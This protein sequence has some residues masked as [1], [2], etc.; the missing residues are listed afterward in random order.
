MNKHGFTLIESLVSI[1]LLSIC[2]TG[3][4]AFYFNAS[5]IMA[6]TIHKK[7]AMEMANQAVEK[8]KEMGYADL[9]PNSAN[10]V[11]EAAITFGDFTAQARR[12]IKDVV[13]DPPNTKKIEFEVR[14]TQS[15]KIQPRTIN[16]ITYISDI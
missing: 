14:W 1:I 4:I 11:P 15:G 5:E 7:I 9:P 6:L 8:Y 16:L 10:W 12:R 13:G 3:G 2:L